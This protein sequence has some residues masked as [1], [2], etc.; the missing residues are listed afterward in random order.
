MDFFNYE[1]EATVK[2]NKKIKQKKSKKL[3]QETKFMDYFEVAEV[4][5]TDE[6]PVKTKS[7]IYTAPSVGKIVNTVGVSC[8]R[9]VENTRLYVYIYM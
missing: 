4:T 2:K 1:D 5:A 8:Y 6:V 7:P 3:E 9:Y